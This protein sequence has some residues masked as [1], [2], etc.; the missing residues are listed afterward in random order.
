[1]SAVDVI[2]RRAKAY[3]LS[4]PGA[5]TI[6]DG[7]ATAGAATSINI[8]AVVQQMT[9]KDLRNLPPGQ[10]AGEWINIWSEDEMKLNDEIPFRGVNFTIQRISLW[11]DGPFYIANANHTFDNT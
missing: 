7:I 2:R 9:S 11:E 3:I 1:M 5:A 10:N 8:K 6:T 4:R